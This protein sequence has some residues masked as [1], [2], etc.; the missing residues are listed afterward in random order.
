MPE[1]SVGAYIREIKTCF[2]FP[3]LTIEDVL[4]CEYSKVVAQP[5]LLSEIYFL[6]QLRPVEEFQSYS[7]N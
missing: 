3:I 6:K 4:S 1:K 5:P 7:M 2:C